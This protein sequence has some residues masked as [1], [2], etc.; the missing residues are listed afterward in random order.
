MPA[1][2]ELAEALAV[3]M[4]LA[5]VTSEALR[6]ERECSERTWRRW[7][8]GDIPCDVYLALAARLGSQPML[9]AL[10]RHVGMPT[11][12][13]Q[14]AAMAEAYAHAAAQHIRAWEQRGYP[15]REMIMR[16]LEE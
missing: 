5:G 8:R 11:S 6:V 10:H 15:M 3:A 14:V 2:P 16:R 9:D 1:S 12:D 13:E 4:R 7:L